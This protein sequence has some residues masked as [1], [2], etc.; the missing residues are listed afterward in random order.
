MDE[1]L[2]PTTREGKLDRLIEECAEVIKAVTKGRRFGWWPPHS[3]DGVEYDN[4]TH[5]EE[6]LKDPEHAS[7]RCIDLTKVGRA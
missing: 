4:I 5:L 2:L 6:E 1:R 3:F 7:V